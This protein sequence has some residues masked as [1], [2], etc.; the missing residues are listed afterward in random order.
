MDYRI[1]RSRHL[2][3]LEAEVNRLL[4]EDWQLHGGV[5]GA[6]LGDK[7]YIFMQAMTRVREGMEG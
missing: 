7:S 4:R 6:E 5:A 3:G 2:S 1:V